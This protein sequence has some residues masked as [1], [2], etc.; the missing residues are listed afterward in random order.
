MVLKSTPGLAGP[1]S[2][3]SSSRCRCQT[4]PSVGAQI[5][6]IAPIAG[7]VDT[8]ESQTGPSTKLGSLPGRRVAAVAA[9]GL[10]GFGPPFAGMQGQ[11]LCSM[12]RLVPYVTGSCGCRVA[13]RSAHAPSGCRV[14]IRSAPACL[15]AWRLGPLTSSRRVAK[16][17]RSAPACLVAWRLG[18]LTSCLVA[19]RLGPLT[20]SPHTVAIRSAYGMFHDS[21]RGD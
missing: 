4:T 21:L 19:W 3:V 18:P 1:E 7:E 6:P 12:S 9:P 14:A 11:L 5:R 2:C 20:L 8:S 10:V 16:P 15:V 13:I 17:I